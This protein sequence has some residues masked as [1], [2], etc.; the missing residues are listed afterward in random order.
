MKN[1]RALGFDIKTLV[2]NNPEL[3]ERLDQNTKNLLNQER[4]NPGKKILR[5]IERELAY[6]FSTA[7][8]VGFGATAKSPLF[9]LA[10]AKAVGINDFETGMLTAYDCIIAGLKFMYAGSASASTGDKRYSNLMYSRTSLALSGTLDLN[11]NEAGV[12]GTPVPNLHVPADFHN[13]NLIICVNEEEKVRRPI[14]QLLI[15]NDRKD[16]LN[17]E[18]S[19]FLSLEHEPIFVAKGQSVTAYIQP[20]EG[21]A[22]AAAALSFHHIR[23]SLKVSTFEKI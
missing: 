21:I 7:T 14:H 19:D 15:E 23:W 2:M 17:G 5:A 3:F 22:I 12:Q 13:A 6:Y 11:A 1:N 18:I 10:Q 16:Y 20:P 8:G 4:A 9:S